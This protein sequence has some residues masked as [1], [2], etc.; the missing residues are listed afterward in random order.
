MKK[1]YLFLFVFALMSV[2]NGQEKTRLEKEKE[3]IKAVILEE[4]QS[5][6]DKDFERF[7]ACYKHDES[8]GELRAYSTNYTH[9]VGW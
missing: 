1:M 9:N 7:A 6:F 2:A 8:I 4:T 5:Y 3:A